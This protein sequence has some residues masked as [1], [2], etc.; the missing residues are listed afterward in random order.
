MFIKFT[1]VKLVLL[2]DR[3]ILLGVHIAL[4]LDAIQ[5]SQAT[6]NDKDKEEEEK[7]TSG[8]IGCDVEID[9]LV[10]DG[11]FISLLRCCS[12]DA[13]AVGGG[14]TTRHHCGL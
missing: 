10:V 8:D 14:E 7:K 2:S 11:P 12:V 5:A 1:K 13:A 3:R 6:C 4:A 9:T